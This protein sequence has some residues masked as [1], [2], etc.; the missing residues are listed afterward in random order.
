MAD[1]KL[2]VA[3]I[4]LLIASVFIFRS[5]WTLM[6]R[7]PLLNLSWILWVLLL[8]GIATSVITLSYMARKNKK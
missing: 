8:T 4:G 2:V 5:M 7:V 6:D 1:R 3:E